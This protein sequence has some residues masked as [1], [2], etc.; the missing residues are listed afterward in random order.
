MPSKIELKGFKEFQAKLKD[1]PK[2]LFS[3]VDGE[4]EDA[5]NTWTGF[6]KRDAPKD[7]GFLA[8]GIEPKK[9]KEMH[10][11]VDS[12]AEY[13]AYVEWGTGTKVS[14][15]S[16][17]QSYASQFKGKGGSA[18]DAKKMIYAWMERVGIP[19]EK[20]WAVFISIMTNGTKPHPFFF[21]QRPIVEKELFKN[22]ENILNTPI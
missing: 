1:A 11:E 3:E 14:V 16:G 13:S 17:L 7:M 20:Q 2:K 15:P 4:V 19:K 8:R 5:A 22:V 21:I 9:V 6:A 10:Y 18:E 12:N